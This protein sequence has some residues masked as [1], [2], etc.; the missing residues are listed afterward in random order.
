MF[1]SNPFAELSTT[2][3][4]DVI[5]GYVVLM[6]ILVVGGT[7]FDVIHKRSAKYFFDK[8]KAAEAARTRDLSGGDKVGIAIQTAVVD[9]ATSA[10]FCS[11]NRRIAHLLTMYGFILFILSTVA[12]VF[13][14]PTD[15]APDIV[16]V[17]WHVGALMVMIGG[18][19]FWFFIRVDVAAEANAWYR[20]VKADLFVLSLL[21]TTTFGFLWS[22]AQSAGSAFWSSLLLALFLIASTVLF[23]GVVWS[24]FAHMFFKPAAAYNKRI[25]KADGS[26]ENLPVLGD[27][28]DPALQERFPDIPEYLGTN[29]P[30][31]G[32]GI[33][34]EGPRH[35]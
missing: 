6:F 2:I 14:Y 27:L 23:G 34:R 11:S 22:I 32:L 35:Y 1:A 29:P 28:S 26:M 13:A 20:L 3:P 16:S 19:W 12:L 33:K 18:Y 30:Y 31:M 7:I 8:A 15:A 9:V 5:Q 17:L 25:T 10:E 4:I 21:G 24:K